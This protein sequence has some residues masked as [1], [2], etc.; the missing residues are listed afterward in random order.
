MDPISD[1][2]VVEAKRTGLTAAKFQPALPRI[3]EL[4]VVIG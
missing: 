3:G 4:A 1:L 2:A